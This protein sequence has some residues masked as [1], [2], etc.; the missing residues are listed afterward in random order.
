MSNMSWELRVAWAHVLNDCNN[1][2]SYKIG[3]YSKKSFKKYVA[4]TLVEADRD[5]V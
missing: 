5:M 4:F 3:K 1:N 2:I